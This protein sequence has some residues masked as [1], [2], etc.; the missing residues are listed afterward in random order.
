[1][2]PGKDS[3]GSRKG[4]VVDLSDELSPEELERLR[5]GAASAGCCLKAYALALIF[6]PMGRAAAGER[7]E[8]PGPERKEGA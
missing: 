2:E 4:R 1:M 7:E 5:S 6:R 8:A 3:V